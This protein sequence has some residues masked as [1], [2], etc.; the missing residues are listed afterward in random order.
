M[1]P[2]KWFLGRKRPVQVLLV[3]AAIAGL[4]LLYW[5]ASPLWTTVQGNDAPPDATEVSRGAFSGLAGHQASGDA[6]LL[7]GGDGSYIVRTES[8]SVTN[9]PDIHVWLS[10]SPASVSGGVDLGSVRATLGSA[11]YAVPA[12]VDPTQYGYVL[13]WCNPFAVP[14]G[15]AAMS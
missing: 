6:I 14:F 9:G 5:L 3:V 7:R 1:N 11:N 8:F 12:G 4:L 2:L 13:I 10:D 15:Q